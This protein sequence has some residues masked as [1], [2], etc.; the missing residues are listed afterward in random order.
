MV[1]L[2]KEEELVCGLKRHSV[3][4]IAVGHPP[5]CSSVQP[6]GVSQLR[7]KRPLCQRDVEWGWCRSPSALPPVDEVACISRQAYLFGSSIERLAC[8]VLVLVLALDRLLT[9]LS[10]TLYFSTTAS[11]RLKTRLSLAL[12]RSEALEP[13]RV[14]LGAEV[15]EAQEP[16]LMHSV[17]HL[18]TVNNRTQA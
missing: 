14:C 15:A 11:Q 9:L 13:C 18:R 17:R 1:A 3:H 10:H 8:V 16:I 2:V 6:L 4:D 5:Q 12:A 7:T